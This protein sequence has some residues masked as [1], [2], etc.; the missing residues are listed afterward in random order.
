MSSSDKQDVAVWRRF[1]M[2]RSLSIVIAAALVVPLTVFSA[3]TGWEIRQGADARRVAAAK[4]PAGEYQRVRCWQEGRLI[5]DEGP[6]V[7]ATEWLPYLLKWHGGDGNRARGALFD[8]RNAT[9]LVTSAVQASA[10][11]Y[12]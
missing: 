5:F 4:T 7:T 3:A 11:P 2:R 12:P 1:T 9:C 8:T 10:P 6:V